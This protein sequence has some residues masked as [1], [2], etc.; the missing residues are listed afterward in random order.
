VVVWHCDAPSRRKLFEKSRWEGQHCC[1]TTLR[2]HSKIKDEF[3]KRVAE[4]AEK[5]IEL[6]GRDFAMGTL[7]LAARFQA[8]ESYLKKV[9]GKVSTAAIPPCVPIAR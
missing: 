1:H 5:M 3:F 9:G 6:H 8:A 2:T 4:L 7:V